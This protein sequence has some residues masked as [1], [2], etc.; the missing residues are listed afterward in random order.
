[1]SRQWRKG[2]ITLVPGYWL[3]D[4][5]GE[6]AES[7]DGI[8]FAVEGGFVNIRVEGREDVQLVSAPAVAHIRCDSRD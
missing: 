8:E 6:R 2:A 1:M 3:L 7:L 5:A 4:A